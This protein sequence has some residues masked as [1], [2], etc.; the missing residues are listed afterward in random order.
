LASLIAHR[1]RWLAEIQLKLVWDLEDI[2][3]LTGLSRRLL[4]RELAAGRMPKPDLR[5]GR[6][7]LW[8][9]RTIRSWLGIEEG[10][11]S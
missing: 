7:C 5:V 1:Q 6:R 4:E 8:R 11:R 9:P 3:L 2:R 10:G